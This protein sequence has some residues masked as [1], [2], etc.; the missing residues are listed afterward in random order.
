MAVNEYKEGRSPYGCFQ[1][2]GNVYEWLNESPDQDSDFKFLAGGCWAVSCELL[3][4]PFLRHLAVK[5]SKGYLEGNRDVFGFRCVRDIEQ[6]DLASKKPSLSQSQDRCPVCNGDLIS[7][8]LSD[9][10]T[11]QKNIFSWN[12]YFDVE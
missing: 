4:I 7:F 9:I 5:K 8:R 6:P 3:G 2:V 10:K 1:M 12:G 11:P